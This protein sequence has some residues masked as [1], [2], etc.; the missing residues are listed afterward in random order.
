M[1]NPQQQQSR[2]VATASLSF[3]RLPFYDV[4]GPLMPSTTLQP[5]GAARCCSVVFSFRSSLVF[6]FQEAAVSFT[7]SLEQAD[8]VAGGRDTRPA[9]K[10]S[11][12]LQTQ[13]RF[14]Q[15]NKWQDG[16]GYR[17]AKAFSILDN[18]IH[19]HCHAQADSS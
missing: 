11:H 1:V 12:R 13:L 16:S 3:S 2:A 4:L 6:R 19:M 5:R 17:C 18:L 9:S 10:L 15:V 7:F 14:C 8:R